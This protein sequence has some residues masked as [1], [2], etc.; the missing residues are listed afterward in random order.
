[1]KVYRISGTFL[2]GDNTQHFTKEILGKGKADAVEIIYSI[3]GS[4]HKVKRRNI[5]F[6]KITEIKA[7][8]A[9]DPIVQ[10]LAGGKVDK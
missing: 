9:E 2:M 5:K 1:M 7:E 10:H 8:K 3:L 4:K 6:T